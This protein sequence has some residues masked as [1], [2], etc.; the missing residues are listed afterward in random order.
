MRRTWSWHA[1]RKQQDFYMDLPAHLTHEKTNGALL[2]ILVQMGKGMCRERKNAWVCV[3][4][5]NH[6]PFLL[7]ELHDQ[8]SL[9]TSEFRAGHGLVGGICVYT[10]T[11]LCRLSEY[12]G[13]PWTLSPEYCLLEGRALSHSSCLPV[14]STIS[15][16]CTCSVNLKSGHFSYE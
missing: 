1:G 8:K 9:E 16:Q 10:P 12:S 3:Q 11:P 7:T 15:A 4:S 6:V 13:C 2:V 14:T 5:M